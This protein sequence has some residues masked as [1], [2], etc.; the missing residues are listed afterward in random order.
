M[1]LSLRDPRG[2]EIDHALVEGPQ[3]AVYNAMRILSRRPGRPLSR[4]MT[5]SFFI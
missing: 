3:D 4:A 2:A 1:R 5:R